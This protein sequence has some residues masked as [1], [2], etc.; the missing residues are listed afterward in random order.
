MNYAIAL[1][2]TLTLIFLSSNVISILLDDDNFIRFNSNI[3]HDPNN[4][5][6]ADDDNDDDANNVVVMI[7]M[8]W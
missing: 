1:L 6:D 2:R 3:R 7:I 8:L 5:N 4:G